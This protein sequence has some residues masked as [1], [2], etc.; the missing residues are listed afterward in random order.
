MFIVPCACVDRRFLP[1]EVRSRLFSPFMITLTQH[2]TLGGG[3]TAIHQGQRSPQLA[4]H[5]PPLASQWMCAS[6]IEHAGSLAETKCPILLARATNGG[7]LLDISWNGPKR[8]CK[9]NKT[10]VLCESSGNTCARV[11]SGYLR[12]QPVLLAAAGWW[13]QRFSYIKRGG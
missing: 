7:I 12:L 4:L 9:E 2:F 6:S 10:S 3:G 5:P 13:R 1:I 8:P 11:C